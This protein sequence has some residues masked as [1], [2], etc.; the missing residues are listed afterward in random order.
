M[1]TEGKNPAITIISVP[2]EAG[3]H[4]PGQRLAP[5][6][7]HSAGLTTKLTSIGYSITTADAL[8]DPVPWKPT[9]LRNGVKNEAASLSVMHS[10]ESTILETPTE[11]VP[12]VLGGDCSSTPAVLSG[13]NKRHPGSKIGLI[14]FDGDAD[15]TLPLKPNED[16]TGFTGILDSM[17]LSHLTQREGS[18]G[19]M[20]AFSTISGGPL[21]SND[22]IVLFGF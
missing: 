6:A 13:L 7:F 17:V 1:S 16:P 15:L 11:N 19:S 18:L 21:V 2:T 22:N 9:T 5:R 4:F 14:Y 20:K 12:L 3:T 8:P 10:V